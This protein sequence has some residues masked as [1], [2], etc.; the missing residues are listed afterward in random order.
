MRLPARSSEFEERA[1]QLGPGLRRDNQAPS[2]L[3]FLYREVLGIDL[4]WLQDLKRPTRPRRIPGVL[5]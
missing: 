3:L 1:S 5:T 2:A 4:P